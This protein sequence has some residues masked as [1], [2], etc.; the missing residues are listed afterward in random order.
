VMSDD[1]MA[2]S[3]ARIPTNKACVVVDVF[4]VSS[5][6]ARARGHQPRIPR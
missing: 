5:D 4:A 1:S 2:D 3:M 6:S